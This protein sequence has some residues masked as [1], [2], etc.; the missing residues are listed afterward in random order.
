MMHHYLSMSNK[1]KIDQSQ[2]P[3]EDQKVRDLK[4]SKTLPLKSENLLL[5]HF[6]IIVSTRLKIDSV[7]D[8]ESRLFIKSMKD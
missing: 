3:R 2:G 7:C 1:I 8:R 5:L 4:S 6:Y